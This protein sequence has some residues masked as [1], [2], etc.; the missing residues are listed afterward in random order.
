MLINP[1]QIALMVWFW[2]CTGAILGFAAQLDKTEILASDNK[3]LG[4]SKRKSR[5]TQE[6]APIQ[7]LAAFIGVLISLSVSLPPYVASVKYLSALK[8]GQVEKI[9]DSASIFPT[10]VTRSVAIINAFSNNQFYSQAHSLALQTVERYPNSF[11]AWNELYLIVNSLPSEKKKALL[12]M[13]RLDPENPQLN[14]E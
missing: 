12:N 5:P 14:G 7:I 10:D 9:F 13:R 3:T 11:A 1:N 4:E 2:A 6:L 8:S